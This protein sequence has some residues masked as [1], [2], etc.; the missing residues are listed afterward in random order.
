MPRITRSSS[1]RPFDGRNVNSHTCAPS[2]LHT[3][4]V[5]RRPTTRTDNLANADP[6]VVATE[7]GSADGTFDD[8]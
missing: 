2:R 5:T 3:V 6:S 4:T 7:S 1:M 8:R